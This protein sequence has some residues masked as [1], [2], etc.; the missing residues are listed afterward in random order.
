VLNQQRQPGI[1]QPQFLAHYLLADVPGG[2]NDQHVD[3][4]GWL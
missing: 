2:A 4:T 1:H 3:L